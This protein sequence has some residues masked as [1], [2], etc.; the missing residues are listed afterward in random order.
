MNGRAT[1]LLGCVLLAG[2]TQ[3]WGRPGS[4]QAEL[5]QDGA[6]CRMVAQGINTPAPPLPVAPRNYA[7]TADAYA[8]SANSLQ[9]TSA[10]LASTGVRL[11]TFDDCMVSRGW[12]RAD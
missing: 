2:C 3:I 9:A 4:T 5:D 1:A 11:R 12:R 6:Y 10:T 8:A 7:T